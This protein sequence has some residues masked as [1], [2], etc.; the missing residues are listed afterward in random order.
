MRFLIRRVIFYLITAWA[1]ITMNFLIP[2]LM[3]GNPVEILLSRFRGRLSPL[4]T[5]SLLELFGLNQHQ[6]I[7]TQYWHYWGQLFRGDLG[8]SFTYFPTPVL[9]VI[10]QS[11][12]WTAVLIGLTTIISFILGTVLGTVI[13]W[14]RGSKWLESLLPATTFFSSIPYFWLALICVFVFSAHLNWFPLSGGYASNTSP[15]LTGTFLGSAIYHGLLPAITIVVSSVAG[16]ILGQRNMMVTTLSEDYVVM[17]EAKGLRDRRVMVAY[18]A[19]NAILPQIAS[20]AMS[21]GFVVSGAILVEIVFSY[22]GIGYVLYQA[23]SNEDFP[24]MQGIFLVITL[25]VLVANFLADLSY[26]LLDPR[27]RQ[28]G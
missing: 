22:P 14:R 24:L 1:A 13:G 16:W 27:T 11:L 17:A 4:A 19:R 15:G 12:P 18:A 8:T 20:F 28:E 6:S 5:Q 7:L 25:A 23:V 10:T 3:P 9:H 21:L 26:A 2:R